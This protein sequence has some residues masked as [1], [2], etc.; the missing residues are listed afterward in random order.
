MTSSD[1]ASPGKDSPYAALRRLI[2]RG[3]L[4]PGARLIEQE[5]ALRLGVSRTPVRE[6]LLRLTTEGLVVPTGTGRRT[7]LAVAPLTAEDVLDVY[8]VMGALEGAAVRRITELSPEE[9]ERLGAVLHEREVAFEAEATKSPVD[10]ER[11]FERHDAFHDAF[12]EVLARPRLRALRASARPLS[13]RYEWCYATL[14]GISTFARTREEHH[15]LITA[16]RAGDAEA[17]VRAVEDNWLQGG[18]H[19]AEVIERVGAR[20][21]W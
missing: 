8:A 2:T 14:V 15:R 18:R 1:D 13:E 11:L 3:R 4:A 16:V 12:F 6:A 20:G 9:R 7:T 10:H 19:L 21:D 17:A 5:L